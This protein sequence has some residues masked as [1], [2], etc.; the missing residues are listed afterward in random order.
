MVYSREGNGKDNSKK[1][2]HAIA[3]V[4][5]KESIDDLFAVSDV[6][7]FTTKRGLPKS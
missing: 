6:P 1:Y 2:W 7:S 4:G 5:G 3:C